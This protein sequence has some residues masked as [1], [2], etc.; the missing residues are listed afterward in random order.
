[1]KNKSLILKIILTIIV[2]VIVTSAIIYL[3]PVVKNLSTTEGQ[4]QFK[5]K[6]S[7][8]G[9]LGLAALFGLQLSQIFLIIIPGEPIEVLAGACY[10][11][12]GGFLFIEISAILI[13]AM[14]ILLVRKLGKNFI[15]NFYSQSK[16][17]KLEKNKILRN[18][19]NIELIMLILFLIPGTPKDLLVYI[20]ALLPIKPFRFILISNIARIPSVISST[21]AGANILKGNWNIS[22]LIYL[23]TFILIGIFV[24]IANK[25]DKNNTTKEVLKSLNS[26][27]N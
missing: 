16:I 1:M 8:L 6:I 7:S 19:K 27:E 20:A 4:L 12:F 9:F 5:E 18:P 22:I 2:I 24:F 13:S 21:Y 23:I 11:G 15:Y 25:Y 3:F 10:G 14:I 26:K 17:E